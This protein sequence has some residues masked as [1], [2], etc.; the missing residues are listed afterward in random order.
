MTTTLILILIL[1][2]RAQAMPN[3]SFI[4]RRMQVN[5]T[6]NKGSFGSGN[7]KVITDLP[8]K[9]SIEKLGPPD[10]A[11]A[12]VEITGM[13]RDEIEKLTTLN[14][15]PMITNRHYINIYAGDDVT[16]LSEVFAGSMISAVGE[17]NSPDVS[18]KIE[19][20]VG[21]WGRVKPQGPSVI[22]A[23]QDV[24]SF[25]SSC[26]SQA[27]MTFTNEGVSAQLK[28]GDMFTGSPVEQARQAANKVGADLLIDDDEMIL[29]N[30][31]GTR[32]GG[33]VPLLSR[34]SGLL[35]YPSIS[36]NGIEFK[37]IFNPA[38]RFAGLVNL[39]SAV[40]KT[41]GEWRIVK[42]THKL[43]ANDP[44]DG[45]WE[46]EITGFYPAMSGAVGRFI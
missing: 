29:I 10:F 31:E 7:S 30:K 14:Y 43:T 33:T 22:N 9:A 2:L 21:F 6:L 20:E 34:D 42:L 19:A 17:F 16:G 46:S 25:I 28:E 1:T 27:D 18:L 44:K 32:S 38:F 26:A 40:P 39:Q 24:A 35:G 15:I 13:S 3:T 8:I 4:K 5:L 12:S 45:S 41:S 23:T 11:K 37:A 36:S